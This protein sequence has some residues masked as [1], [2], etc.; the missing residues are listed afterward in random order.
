[1][2]HPDL[3]LFP[4]YMYEIKDK[5]EEEKEHTGNSTFRYKSQLV[6]PLVNGIKEQSKATSNKNTNS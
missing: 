1:M 5:E 6:E 3:F 2:Y 4:N